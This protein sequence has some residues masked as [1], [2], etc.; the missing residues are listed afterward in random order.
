MPVVSFHH[1]DPTALENFATWCKENPL[2]LLVLSD[3]SGATLHRVGCPHIAPRDAAT[4]RA[5]QLCSADHDE[6]VGH[7]EQELGHP[8]TRCPDCL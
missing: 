6:L 4:Y 7:A 8:P 1:A 2:G 5:R 3:A